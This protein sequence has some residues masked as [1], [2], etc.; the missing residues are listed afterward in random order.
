[1]FEL[2]VRISSH[3]ESPQLETTVLS[4]KSLE[5]LKT[6]ISRMGNLW[7]LGFL[8]SEL[9]SLSVFNLSYSA[10]A[11]LSFSASFKIK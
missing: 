7:P 6:I 11:L 5:D 3:Y 2:A 4:L 10:V 9:C 1:M 8:A